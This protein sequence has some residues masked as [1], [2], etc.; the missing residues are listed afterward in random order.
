[1]KEEEIRK[2]D[3]FD[4][5]LE[6]VEKDVNDFFNFSLFEQVFCPAC[7]SEDYQ[8]EFVKLGFSYVLCR[9]CSTLFVNPRPP[10]FI[11]DKF[12]SSSPSTEFWVKEFF[13]PVAEARRE[14]VFRPR[15]EQISKLVKKPFGNIIGDIGAGFGLFL[16]EL[17]KL[18]PDNDYYAIEPSR[19][20]VDILNMKGLKVI[21]K[22]FEN[23]EG[24]NSFFDVLTAFELME[25]IHNPGIFLKKVYT[26]LRPGGF[27][28]LTTLNGKGFDIL[29]LWEKSKS[30]SP[31][32]HLNFF[33]PLSIKTLLEKIGFNEIEI[34]TP[35]KLDWDIVEGMILRDGVDLGRFWN[36]IARELG[37][38]EKMA[39]QKWIAESNLSSHMMVIAK[40]PLSA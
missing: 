30:V 4:K 24:Y 34:T 18:L 14:K 19:L 11:L 3:V 26:S 40:K 39:L 16:E 8:I 1:M 9:K 28:L 36:L 12:Y 35:G 15:A 33:N 29:L 31:P 22:T 21:D 7:G 37:I 32:H 20:M 38:K 6:L 13:M 5:Y 17:K 25:H 27:F 23:M 2:R 10:S